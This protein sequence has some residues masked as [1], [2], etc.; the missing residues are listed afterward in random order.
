MKKE[1]RWTKTVD[2]TELTAV[3]DVDAETLTVTI[4]YELLSKFLTE[5]G[6]KEVEGV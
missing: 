1:T 5:L 2:G 6:W 3:I 4:T